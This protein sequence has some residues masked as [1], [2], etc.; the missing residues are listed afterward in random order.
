MTATLDSVFNIVNN[1]PY[2]FAVTSE[3]IIGKD[4]SDEN[5]FLDHRR[6]DARR[7]AQETCHDGAAGS[8]TQAVAA[9]ATVPIRPV[10][11][12]FQIL[13][14][15]SIGLIVGRCVAALSACYCIRQGAASF[16][17]PLAESAGGART[18]HRRRRA[19]L[20]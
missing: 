10:P 20:S 17:G 7:S 14:I 15:L 6:F 5:R 1:L 3:N 4:G 9:H 19:D 18:E 12:T 11:M 16:P 13:A 8:L 2:N